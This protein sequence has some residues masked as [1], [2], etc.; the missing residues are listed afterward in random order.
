M[1]NFDLPEFSSPISNWQGQ[2]W[3]IMLGLFPEYSIENEQVILEGK[4]HQGEKGFE[5]T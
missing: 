5:R 3:A 4:H 2:V 1:K